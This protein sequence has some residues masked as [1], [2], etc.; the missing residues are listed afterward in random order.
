ML[1]FE[2]PHCCAQHVNLSMRRQVCHTVH[3]RK[4]SVLR[5]EISPPHVVE[6]YYLKFK[7]INS[8]H[9]RIVPT[10]V[11]C[12]CISLCTLPPSA[13]LLR[14]ASWAST[15]HHGHRTKATRHFA[16]RFE[17]NQMSQHGI[18]NV[19]RKPFRH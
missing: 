11:N 1:C 5:S 18:V 9:S 6:M 7:G 16:I 10:C 19:W 13:S 3:A 17:T 14:S 15:I 4:Y 2:C 8:T 12:S